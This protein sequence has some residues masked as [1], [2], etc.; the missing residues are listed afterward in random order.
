MI[1]GIGLKRLMGRSLP[2]VFISLLGRADG[3]KKISGQDGRKYGEWV[4]PLRSIKGLCGCC[5]KL[6]SQEH[7]C[8]KEIPL[9]ITPTEEPKLKDT[10]LESE[11]NDM[12]ENPQSVTRTFHTPPQILDIDGFIKHQPVTILVNTRSSNDLMNNK[13]K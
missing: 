7:K 4:V 9:M 3:R 11:E 2:N 10:T 6:W 12:K 13:R 5:D 1:S 8:R